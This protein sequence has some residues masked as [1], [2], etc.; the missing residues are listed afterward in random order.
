[1][2]REGERF[3]EIDFLVDAEEW[4]VKAFVADGIVDILEATGKRWGRLRWE[5]GP[6]FKARL[7]RVELEQLEQRLLAAANE[8]PPCNAV[9]HESLKHDAALWDAHT[10]F[11]VGHLERPITDGGDYWLEWANCLACHSTLARVVHPVLRLVN[12]EN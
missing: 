8:P 3:V 7:G 5:S 10:T 4:C 2:P 11:L 6:T 1:V 9:Y 12:Q